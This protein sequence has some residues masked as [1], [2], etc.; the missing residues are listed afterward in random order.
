MR[1]MTAILTTL[2]IIALGSVGAALLVQ[3]AAR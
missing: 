1:L 2:V 3:E